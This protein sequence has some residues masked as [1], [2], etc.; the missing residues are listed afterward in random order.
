[1]WSPVPKG[2]KIVDKLQQNCAWENTEHMYNTWFLI[3]VSE[4]MSAGKGWEEDVIRDA[5]K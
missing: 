5:E 4:K 3:L 2:C 1:M